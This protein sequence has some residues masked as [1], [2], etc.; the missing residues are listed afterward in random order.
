MTTKTYLQQLRHF[1]RMIENK[2]AEVFK[3]RQ[4]AYGMSIRPQEIRVQTSA[5]PD[6]IGATV[7]KIVDLENEIDAI[8]TIYIEKRNTIIRQ[9]E[10]LGDDSESIENIDVLTCRFVNEMDFK[11]IPDVVAMSRRKMFYVYG[12]ALDAFEKKYGREYR[13]L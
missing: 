9:I 11:E 4:I 1:K 2:S 8:V 3:L 12:R 5:E 13:K 10:S 7:A 6:R